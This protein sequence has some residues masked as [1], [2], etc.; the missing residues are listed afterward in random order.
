MDLL[1]AQNRTRTFEHF[2]DLET[3]KNHKP[4]SRKIE[5]VKAATLISFIYHS[6]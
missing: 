2:K 3:L 5:S 6:T 4:S 1:S